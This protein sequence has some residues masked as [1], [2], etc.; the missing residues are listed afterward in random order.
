MPTRP[1]WS[2]SI[3]ISLVSITVKIFPATNP[4]EQIEFHQIAPVCASF[5]R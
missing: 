4:G 1:S 3:Q 2:G 5:G